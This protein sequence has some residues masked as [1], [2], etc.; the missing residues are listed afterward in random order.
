MPLI[1]IQKLR[2]RDVINCIA[3]I[4]FHFNR[5]LPL[6][7]ATLN[8]GH[9]CRMRE[10]KDKY[11]ELKRNLHNSGNENFLELWSSVARICSMCTRSWV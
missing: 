3:F 1:Q 4:L 7:H 9:P 5:Y 11:Q 8:S 10:D 2:T 6:Q